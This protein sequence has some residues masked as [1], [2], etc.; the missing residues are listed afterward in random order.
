M[1]IILY[2]G[3]YHDSMTRVTSLGGDM[4]VWQVHEAK[5]K[6]TEVMNKAKN[7]PQIISRC[8][9][10]EI[11]VINI[12]KYQELCKTKENIISFFKNSPLNEIEVEFSREKSKMREVEL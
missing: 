6:L 8:G 1:T 3:F 7:D 4:K 5:A 12:N 11:V 2:F 10:N 9:I